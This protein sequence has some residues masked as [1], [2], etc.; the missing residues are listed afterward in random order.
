[1][2]VTCT[3]EQSRNNQCGYLIG[4]GVEITEAIQQI[5]IVFEGINVLKDGMKFAELYKVEMTIVEAII[6]KVVKPIEVLHILL[7]REKR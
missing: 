7:G 2:I 3:S 6:N 5:G 4:K 1:M